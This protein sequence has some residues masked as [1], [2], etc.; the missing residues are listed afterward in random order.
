MRIV[1][2]ESEEQ[3][4]IG[5]AI[6]KAR[7]AKGY[8]L[9]ELEAKSGVSRQSIARWEKGIVFPNI[10]PLISVADVLEVTLDELVGRT[11]AR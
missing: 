9:A 8:T 3:M 1:R 7:K 11:V 10:M 2:S 6:K 4:T 5:E